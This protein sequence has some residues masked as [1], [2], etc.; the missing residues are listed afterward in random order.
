[1]QFDSLANY[2]NSASYLHLG[3]GDIAYWQSMK[4]GLDAPYVCFIHGFPSASWD[5]QHQW[6]SLESKYNLIACDLLGFGVSGKPHPHKY[7]VVEQ[8]DIVLAVL[9]HCNIQECHIVA[10]DYGVSVAQ[11]VLSQ[12]DQKALVTATSKVTSA[13]TALTRILSICFLNGGLFAESHRPILTQKLLKSLI[14]PVF[15]KLM[16]K[17]TMRK[18]FNKVFSKHNPPSDHEID[19]FWELLCFEAGTR[20]LPS[21]LTYIDERAVHRDKWVYSMGNATFPIGFINGVHDPVSGQHM[22][23]RFASLFPSYPSKGIDVGHYP[24]LEDAQLVTSLIELF[25]ATGKLS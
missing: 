21:I 15:A 25:L 3:Q 16:S 11:E 13:N 1:M 10:H 24:Q 2:K 22:L 20:V 19:M 5:W 7:S 4:A 6:Q 17:S 9:A 23:E 12:L 18:G 14:G 8:A